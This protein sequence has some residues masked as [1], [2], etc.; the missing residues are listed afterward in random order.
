[1][2]EKTYIYGLLCPV[3]NKIRY[4]G[5]SR[6]VAERFAH[7]IKL[8]DRPA[9]TK[10]HT[11]KHRWIMELADQGLEPKLVILESVDTGIE[12]EDGRM[13][14]NEAAWIDAE[15]RWIDRLRDEGHPLTNSDKASKKEKSNRQVIQEALELGRE[16][17]G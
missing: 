10:Y 17:F 3:E 7:H 11:P 4:V 6:K 14:W 5:R 8:H 16:M 13:Y 2:S 1:M 12:G 15:R 9:K